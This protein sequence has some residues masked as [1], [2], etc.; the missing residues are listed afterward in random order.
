MVECRLAVVVNS[1][2]FLCWTTMHERVL[3]RNST[4]YQTAVGPTVPPREFDIFCKIAFNNNIFPMEQKH[5]W[6]KIS[7]AMGSPVIANI[8]MKTLEEKHQY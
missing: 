1:S 5:I 4:H 7:A 8:S 2:K 3:W 6:T